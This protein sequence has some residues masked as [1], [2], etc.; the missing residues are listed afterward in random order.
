MPRRRVSVPFVGRSTPVL[1]EAPLVLGLD[2]D[3]EPIEIHVW[4][5]AMWGRLPVE[6][7][8]AD[9]RR[10]SGGCRWVLRRKARPGP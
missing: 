9:V 1:A 6:D 10:G 5:E 8:P 4:T 3:G 7:R 2:L